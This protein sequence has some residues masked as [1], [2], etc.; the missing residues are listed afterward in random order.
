MLQFIVFFIVSA[1]FVL[2]CLAQTDTQARAV[3]TSRMSIGVVGGATLNSFGS[4]TRVQTDTNYGVGPYYDTQSGMGWMIGVDFGAPLSDAPSWK[5][6]LDLR[7][8]FATA[9]LD[10]VKQGVQ[11]P[12]LD[13]DGDT[14]YS[15]LDHS[16]TVSYSVIDLAPSLLIG[17][18]N[19]P[20][21]FSIGGSV[22]LIVSSNMKE[23]LTLINPLNATF[24]P[25]FCPECE[26]SSDQRSVVITDGD[27]EGVASVQA[28][29]FAGVEYL[30]ALED[31]EFLSTLRYRLGLTD[32]S[33][34]YNM[35][36]NALELSVAM[37]VYL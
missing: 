33:T 11:L 32:I 4:G 13:E 14:V 35:R 15:I 3:N 37:R 19:T 9:N 12:S 30:L 5:R 10:L 1:S 28:T 23:T 16:G 29:A 18:G 2:P 31:V 6:S 26:Y 8:S 25:S 17:I 7:L 20:F 36:V 22:G 27:I 34:A 21:S 24:D